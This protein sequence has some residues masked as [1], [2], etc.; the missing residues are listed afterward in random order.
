VKVDPLSGCH[1]WQAAVDNTGYGRI[2]LDGQVHLAHRLAWVVK[3]GPLPRNKVV[4]HRCDERRC[5]NPDH[6]FVDTHAGNMA[7]MKRKWRDRRRLG[8]SNF[9]RHGGL[10][11]DAHPSEIAPI[12]I[13][14]GEFELL[15]DA[16]LRPIRPGAPSAARD[17]ATASIEAEALPLSAQQSSASP[18]GKRARR[19]SRRSPGTRLQ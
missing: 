4:C 2:R 5:L 18:D 11:L 10:P 7:D 9:R 12:R 19:S 15:G 6:L 8:L 16:V 13:I 3:Y 14:C 17:P 1:I